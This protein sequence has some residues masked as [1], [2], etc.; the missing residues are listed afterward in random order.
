[1]THSVRFVPGTLLALALLTAGCAGSRMPPPDMSAARS[2]IAEADQSGAGEAAPL[3]LRN[4][5]QK[6]EQAERAIENE[7]Y[8]TARFLTDQAQVDAELAEAKARSAMATTAVDELR[9]SIR[10]LREEINRSRP[11]SGGR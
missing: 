5:R 11:N 3:A 9:E 1:M 7:D 6:L 4:A 10:V 2:A 8:E